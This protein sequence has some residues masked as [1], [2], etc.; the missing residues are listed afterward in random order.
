MEWA[1]PIQSFDIKK[2]CISN[3][4]R[5]NKP[6]ATLSYLD[7]EIT[8]PY[9]S[10]LL[11][12]LPIKS[13]DA[14]SGRLS[15][16]LHGSPGLAAKLTALQNHILQTTFENF[17]SW[18]PAER[19]RTYDEIVNYFQPLISHGCI[20]LYCP[21]STP[22]IFNDIQVYSKGVWTKGSIS[23]DTFSAG[24]SMRIAVR[25]Q[26]ISL[27]QHLILKKLTGKSRVQHRIIAI[28]ADS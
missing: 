15:I 5:G 10:I 17:S 6:M 8:F 13:Y 14:E 19:K 9:L 26:G 3:I 27:H 28:Y 22:G 16:S 7:G 23:S 4:S 1:I 2:V 11:P 24:K 18:F 20:H 12:P 21:A 25:F